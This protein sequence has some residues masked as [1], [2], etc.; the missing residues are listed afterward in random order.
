MSLNLGL[1]GQPDDLMEFHFYPQRQGG[2]SRPI[3]G[4]GWMFP[5]DH[6]ANIGAGGA[7]LNRSSITAKVRG[8]EASCAAR[9]GQVTWRE[10]LAGHPLPLYVR[11]RLHSRRSMAVG[12]AGGL[13]N[14]ITGEG[15]TY[16]FASASLASAAAVDLVRGGD[17]GATAGYERR[18][19]ESMVRDLDAARLIQGAV[20]SLLGTLDLERFFD[21]FCASEEL[22]AAC[23][24]I[25]RDE[26][27]WRL[28]LRRALPRVPALYLRSL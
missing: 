4:Y 28:L 26:S 24:G 1:E 19:R 14:P 12:D 6:G 8:I 16:A 9:Y 18:C 23:L 13:A 5:T 22:R 25:V 7:G 15:M 11:R 17:A 10:E 2:R 27:D 21:A 20:R 3:Y